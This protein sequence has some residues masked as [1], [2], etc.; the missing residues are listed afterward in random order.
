[1]TFGSFFFFWLFSVGLLAFYP[2]IETGLLYHRRVIHR[3]DC[4]WVKV[5]F[6]SLCHRETEIVIRVSVH[7]ASLLSKENKLLYFL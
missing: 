4:K 7:R 5:Y 3:K 2:I 1:M 6:L